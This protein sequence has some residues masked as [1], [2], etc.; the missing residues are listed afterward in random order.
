MALIS[1]MNVLFIFKWKENLQ[2]RWWLTTLAWL[3]PAGFIAVEAGWIVT[4][5]GRQPW[6][7]YGIMRTSESVTPMPGIVYSLYLITFIYLA[8][9]LIVFLLMKRQ[10]AALQKDVHR[11]F[12]HD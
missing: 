4:E 8:L 3:T 12:S 11:G 7:I 2:K 10:I 1:L 6:I 9:T 5:T